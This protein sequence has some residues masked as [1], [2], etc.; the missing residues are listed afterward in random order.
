[1]RYPIVLVVAVIVFARQG[2]GQTKVDLTTQSKSVVD[3]SAATSTKPLVTGAALPATC[4][5]GQMYF[6]T[7]ATSGQNTYGCVALNTWTVQS[8]GGQSTTIRSSGLLVGSRPVIDVSA[9]RGGLLATSDTGTEISVQAS[10][11]TSFIQTRADHQSGTALFCASR[12]TASP[13]LV[14]FCAMM[15]TLTAYT[16]GM[17][18]NW[19]PDVT[20]S[21]GA[22]T[23]DVDILGAMPIVRADGITSPVGSDF[24]AGRLYQ[25]WYDGAVFRLPGSASSIGGATGSAGALAA[26]AEY[27]TSMIMDSSYCPNWLGTFTGSS[28][29]TFTLGPP[30]AGCLIGLQNNTTLPMTINITTNSVTLNGQP[31][32]GTIPGCATPAN[33]CKVAIIKANG[34]TSWDMS[35]AGAD[36]NAGP[37]GVAR[38][39]G[40]VFAG[41]DVAAG[42]AINIPSLDFSCTLSKAT[43]SAGGGT[44]TIKLWKVAAGGTAI[45][46]QGDSI[47][48]AGFS[49]TTGS[50]YTT[51]N[52]ADLSTAS[53]TAGDSLTFNL[54]ALSGSPDHVGISMECAQ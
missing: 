51:A 36:V 29:L 52:M 20:N 25:L 46:T 27:S 40:V 53:I 16:R 7:T 28:A 5:T 11:D 8:A 18:V 30:V 21:G 24:V 44:A 43:I 41:A 42:A 13:G 31:S 48:T 12:S 49:L 17:V 10:I 38:N 15:P 45:P 33:G 34:T 19:Q 37:S 35:A 2:A 26:N 50:K 14:Y 3:F 47:S 54:F 6:L 1:M 39:I 22:I 4:T 9:G 23:L 32:N